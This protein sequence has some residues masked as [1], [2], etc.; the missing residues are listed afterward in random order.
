[1]LISESKIDE[2]CASYAV[3]KKENDMRDY[4]FHWTPILV[5]INY[6]LNPTSLSHFFIQD[7]PGWSTYFILHVNEYYCFRILI[8]LLAYLIELFLMD[9]KLWFKLPKIRYSGHFMNRSHSG[10]QTKEKLS[11]LSKCRRY[12]AALAISCL[13]FGPRKRLIS[14]AVLQKLYR[15]LDVECLQLFIERSYFPGFNLFEGPC[16]KLQ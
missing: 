2:F 11:V 10:I 6:I 14:S 12:Q 16:F 7:Y 5:G 13:H 3:K 4:I 1:M 9:H 15:G 8:L